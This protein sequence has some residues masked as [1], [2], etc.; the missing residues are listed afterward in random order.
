MIKTKC[1]HLREYFVTLGMVAWNMGWKMIGPG[2]DVEEK[3]I[4]AAISEKQNWTVKSSSV[5][6]TKHLLSDYYLWDCAKFW[7]P[8]VG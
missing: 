1:M 5:Q 3:C 2:P 4:I 8:E 6:S 7:E